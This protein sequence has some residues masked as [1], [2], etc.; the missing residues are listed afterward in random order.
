[1]KKKAEGMV[2]EEVQEELELELHPPSIFRLGLKLNQDLPREQ[3]LMEIKLLLPINRSPLHQPVE[4]EIQVRMEL[5]QS[6]HHLHL[7]QVLDQRL[8]ERL[9]FLVLL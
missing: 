6:H 8:L 4:L 7:H 3:E 2:E 5:Y 9:P 1:M